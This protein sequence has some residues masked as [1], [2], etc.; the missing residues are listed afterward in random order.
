MDTQTIDPQMLEQARILAALQAQGG[1]RPAPRLDDEPRANYGRAILV[2]LITGAA[3]WY[4]MFAWGYSSLELSTTHNIAAAMAGMAM[5]TSPVCLLAGGT[6]LAVYQI[7]AGTACVV[8]GSVALCAVMITV[9]A[10]PEHY[11]EHT[12]A[13]LLAMIA[14]GA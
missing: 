11:A 12:G 14:G 10:R 9:L 8:A 4:A 1:K 3:L 5:I 2:A 7:R 6:A 13:R